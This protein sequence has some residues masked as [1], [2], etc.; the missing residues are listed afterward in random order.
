VRVLVAHQN[1]PGQFG[2]LVRA[3]AQRPGWQVRALGRDTAPGLA[4]FEA[5]TRYRLARPARPHQH[6]YL[7]RMESAALHG[8]ATARAM[9][10]MKRGG[11]VPDVIL[12][13]PGWGETLYAKDVCPDARLVHFS[14][15]YYAAHGAD[16]GFDPEFPASLDDHARV[17]TWNAVH[18]LNLLHCD[19]AVSPTRWQRDR[20]P[21]PLRDKIA[22]QH[23]GIDID[24][25]QPDTGAH[26]VTPSGLVLRHGDPVVTFVARNLEP[27]RG[28]HVFMRALQRIQRQHARA[29]AVIVGGDSIS[30]GRAPKDAPN[31]RERLLREVTIDPARTHFTGRL[32]YSQYLRVLQVSAA[33]I[34]LTYP[35]VLGWSMLEAMACGALVIGSDT[36]PVREVIRHG[37]NGL[38]VPFFDDR[39]LAETV[40]SAL[41]APTEFAEIRSRARADMAFFSRQAGLAGYDALLSDAA[42]AGVTGGA[43][44][45]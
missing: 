35:F 21:M 19:A 25:L 13:H 3:W 27:Y 7:R 17:R 26:I 42:P 22:V 32:P 43:A 38:L 30:Y 23:E 18:A 37:E 14:E 4:G 6:A 2:H 5:L 31:W 36:A 8:Q 9:L 39:R 16:V 34:Y 15:W 40:G 29:H 44:P 45:H 33:H 12:A 11:F 10:Q 20:H 24:R 28:F 41:E 1:F